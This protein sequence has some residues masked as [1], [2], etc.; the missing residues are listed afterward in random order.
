[1]RA[2]FSG[3]AGFTR[4]YAGGEWLV[5]TRYS[6]WEAFGKAQDGLAKDPAWAKLI[7]N[8]AGIARLMGRNIHVSVER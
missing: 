2:N 4:A 3:Y 1:M 7:A 5:V 8:T 6:S